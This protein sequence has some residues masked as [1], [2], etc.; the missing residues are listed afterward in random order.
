MSRRVSIF[1][2]AL[3]IGVLALLLA[4][5]FAL[6]TAV[7]PLRAASVIPVIEQ[8]APVFTTSDE[9]LLNGVY[10]RVS[11][12]VVSINVIARTP[13]VMQ[14]DDDFAFGRGT[15]FVIDTDGHIVTN[16][17]VIE[18]AVRIEVN[19]IDGT[20]ALAEIV[21]EDPD[22]DLAVIRV[23]DVPVERLIPVGFADSNALFTGQEVVAI[24]SP[25]NQR[26]TM[27][28]GIIS[29]LGR[30]ILGVN[31]YR[32]GSVIQTDAAINPGNSGGP[33][34]NLQGQVIGVNSQIIS[35]NN[36]NSGIGFAIPA[37][38]VQRVM[39]SLIETGEVEYGFLGIGGD[40][41]NLY[42][43]EALNLPNNTRGA[44]VNGVE[45]GS[46]ADR[47]GLRGAGGRGIEIDGILVPTELD[48]ITAVDGVPVTGM[49]DLVGYLAENTIPGQT[50]QL[51]VLRN[52]D[53]TLSLP[54][55][56]D[57]RP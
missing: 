55:T 19:F 53:E 41:V 37:N 30:S 52:G 50:I 57:A 5:A 21:G 42:F 18:G 22:S 35:A 44:V 28:T 12:S 25:F 40:D 15:G 47:A 38:L 17:H 14:M 16:Y 54:L 43:I 23:D 20:I 10:Q 31:N 56:L 9:Q 33:L 3:R 1:R 26:W 2:A 29:G 34:L 49:A 36:S 48:I 32:I 13:S 46:A 6:G 27:T 24:G 45:R 51:S 7:V 4:G 8:A 39:R 11:P